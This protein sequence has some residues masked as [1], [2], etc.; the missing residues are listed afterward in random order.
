MTAR[1]AQEHLAEVAMELWLLGELRGDQVEAASAHIAVCAE[2]RASYD[3][4]QDAANEFEAS[5]HARTAPRVLHRLAARH[6]Q[7]RSNR[8]VWYSSILALA[9]LG[10]LLLVRT[11]HHKQA[12]TES[13]AILE[14]G[15]PSLAVFVRRHSGRVSRLVDGARVDP[16]DLLRFAVDPGPYPY[17]LIAS[18][19]ATGRVSIYLPFGGRQSLAVAPNR[20]YEPDSSIELDDV[21]GPERIV[22]F[23][24]Q[25]PLQAAQV[26]GVLARVGKGGSGAIRGQSRV[27][28]SGSYEDSLLLEK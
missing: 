7:P 18:V 15:S 11:G 2:C 20:R 3:S 26:T 28:V 9:S 19:D 13:A 27:E 1:P 23:F 10:L 12:V 5:V 14:K 21:R 25:Q 22:A 8:P 16:G 4:L 6:Q 24:S 17:L